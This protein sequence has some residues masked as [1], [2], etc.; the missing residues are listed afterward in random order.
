MT[1]F[2]RHLPRRGFIPLAASG[3]GG[4]GPV[5]GPPT[6]GRAAFP[7]RLL[8]RLVR[9]AFSAVRL[10]DPARDGPAIDE[11]QPSDCWPME[12]VSGQFLFHGA[13]IAIT[14]ASLSAGKSGEFT[15]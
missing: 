4:G 12:V 7:R 3:T 14:R 8:S 2:D 11:L 1:G 13:D 15:A 9:R 6:N 10:Q 5:G